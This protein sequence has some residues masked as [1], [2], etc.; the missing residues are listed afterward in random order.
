MSANCLP[1]LA[2]SGDR[3]KRRHRQNAHQRKDRPLD[4]PLGDKPDAGD[5]D[6]QT[7]QSGHGFEDRR[8]NRQI[9]EKRKPQIVMHLHALDELA[10]PFRFLLKC[11]YFAQ[12][13]NG[14]DAV[15]VQIAQRLA[16]PRPQLIDPTAHQKRAEDDNRQERH[17]RG[18]HSANRTKPA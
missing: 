8:L 5:D 15:R 9:A 4:R 2:I 11:S 3:Q 17:Q 12:S 13:L 7:A 1:I 18:R 10:A 6:N 16:C 14:V